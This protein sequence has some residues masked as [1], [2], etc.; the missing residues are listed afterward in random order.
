MVV[1][2]LRD[3]VTVPYY[4]AVNQLRRRNETRGNAVKVSK[5]NTKNLFYFDFITTVL[6]G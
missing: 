2:L 3:N 4:V 5:R 6:S 1:I